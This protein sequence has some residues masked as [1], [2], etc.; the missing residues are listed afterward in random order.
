MYRPSSKWRNLVLLLLTACAFVLPARSDEVTDYLEQLG[1]KDLLAVHLEQQLEVAP[2][3]QRA[4]IVAKLAGLYAEILESTHDEARR[5]SLEQRG[6]RLLA[7]APEASVDELRLALLRASYRSAER[8]AEQH[9][10]RL[11]T[12]AEVDAAR[13]NLTE[14]VRDVNSLRLQLRD[15]LEVAERRLSRS[16]GAESIALSQTVE[17]LRSLRAQ[18]TFLQAWSMY[19]QAW[20][21]GTGETARG[22]EPLFAELMGT[23]S[24]TPLPEDI[25]W[26]RPGAEARARSRSTR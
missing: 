16:I 3:D 12:P 20:L 1:L 25:S 24:T 5:A 19:Y 15:K 18:A 11:S 2:S 21:A 9:R 10:L 8:A 7:L 22:A 14:I 4:E 6:R 26:K 17:R 13:A 23:E